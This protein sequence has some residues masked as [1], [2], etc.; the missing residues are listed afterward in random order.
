MVLLKRA[1]ILVSD[2]FGCLKE[3]MPAEDGLDSLS[4][5]ADYRVPQVLAFFEALEYSI[6]LKD[7]LRKSKSLF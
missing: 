3:H 5:F 4:M 6:E 7:V 1:Q 2:V